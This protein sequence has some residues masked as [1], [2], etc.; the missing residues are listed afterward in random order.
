MK[1]AEREEK[2]VRLGGKKR[3]IEGSAPAALLKKL[4]ATGKKKKKESRPKTE[5]GRGREDRKE[6]DGDQNP[7]LESKRHVRISP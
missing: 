3:L 2:V 7:H 1:E 6:R 4:S 5:Q